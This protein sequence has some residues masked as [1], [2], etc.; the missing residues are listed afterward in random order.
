[1]TSEHD[2]AVLNSILNPLLPVGEA[3]FLADEPLQDNEEENAEAKERELEG[4][5]AAEAGKLDDAVEI[6]TSAIEIAPE[7]ASGYNNRAQALRLKGKIPEALLDLNKALSFSGGVGKSACQALCQRAQ[8]FMKEG[9]EDLAKKDLEAA[10]SQGNAFAKLQLAQ[11]NPYAALCNK[12]L[13]DAF[14]KLQK[15][16][17]DCQ[18]KF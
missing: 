10:A 8:I 18:P 4:V 11:M 7:R 16:E 1:M 2:R 17:M 9:H 12:M 13:H 14:T 6:F 5:R 15:G 3:A